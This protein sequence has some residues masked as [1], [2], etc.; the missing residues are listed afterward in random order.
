M[1]RRGEGRR[2]GKVQCVEGLQRGARGQ[3]HHGN[4][5]HLVHCA[6]AQYLDPQQFV[7]GFV[8]DQLGD[9]GAGPGIIVCLVIGHADD[10]GGV[11]AGIPGLGFGQGPVRPAFR[12]S[13]RR[14]T[15]V[16]RH[17]P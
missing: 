13:A 14:T 16:P 8:G 10:G 15:P 3:A 5:H 2:I 1:D 17:P 12:L 11:I 9:K 4:I 7:A 6:R